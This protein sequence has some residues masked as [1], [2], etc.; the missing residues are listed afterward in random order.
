MWTYNTHLATRP[1][2][3]NIIFIL[4]YQ[5][6]VHI[7]RCIFEKVWAK[8]KKVIYLF[9]GVLGQVIKAELA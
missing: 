2:H 8:K 5:T 3:N 1:K 7:N 4:I 6:D 9:F